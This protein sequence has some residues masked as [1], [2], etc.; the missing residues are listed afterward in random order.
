MTVNTSV[1]A[2]TTV[3]FGPSSAAP[4]ARGFHLADALLCVG[5][6]VCLFTVADVFIEDCKGLKF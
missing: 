1:I 5:A 2:R 3:P 6:A 4:R